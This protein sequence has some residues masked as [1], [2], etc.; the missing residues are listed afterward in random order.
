MKKIVKFFIENQLLVYLGLIVVVIFGV[1][2]GSKMNTSFFPAEKEK[3]ILIEAVYPGASPQEIEEGITLKIEDNLK[4]VSGIDRV[5]SVSYENS[6]RITVEILLRSN[7][8]Q[9]LQDVKNAVDQIANFPEGMERIVTYKQEIINFTAKLAVVGDVSLAALEETAT[10]VEDELR[11]IPGI[12]KL[13]VSGYPD[14]E[15]EVAVKEDKLRAYD[16]TFSDIAA[17]VSAQNIEVTGGR[18]KGAEETIIRSNNK[19]YNANQL[20]DVVVKSLPDGTQLKLSELAELREDWDESTN[21]GYLNGKRAVFI[22]VNTLNEEDILSA[23]D[24]VE[25]YVANFSNPNPEVQLVLVKDGTVTLKERI[26]LLQKNGILGAILVFVILALF[27]RIRLAFWVALGIPV[28]FLGMFILLYFTGITIN[29]LSLFG[30]ILVI[31]ILVDDGIVVG[32]NIFQ[33]Y[34]RGKKPFR[35]VVDGTVEVFPS[36]FSAIFTTCVAFSFFYFVDGRLGEFFSDVAIVVSAAL[37]FSLIEVIFFLPAH[38]AHSKDLS[39]QG[40]PG[41]LKD[42]IEQLLFRFR[43][44]IFEPVLEFCLRYKVFTFFVG[45]ALFVLTIAAIGGGLI[46]TTFFP[47]IEQ[48]EITVGLEMP[49]GTSEKVTHEAMKYIVRRIEALNQSYEAREDVGK[50][51]YTDV[52]M[53]L[54]PRSNEGK[55]TFYLVSSE[56]RSLRSFDITNDM[57]QAVGGIPDAEKLSFVAFSPFGKA[58]NV[59]FS[60]PDFEKLRAAVADF[61]EQLE[62][63]GKVKDLLTNDRADQPEI[64]LALNEAGR[65][66][67]FSERALIAQVRSGFF[68]FEAQRLQRGDKEVKVWVRYDIDDRRS[69]QQLRQMRVRAPGGEL[70]ALSDIAEFQP[71]K[72]LININH[73]NGRREITVEGEVASLDVS[74]P[75]LLAQMQDEILPTVLGRYPGV[76]VS[77]EGQQRETG[78]LQASTKTAGPIILLVILITLIISFRS[79]TQALALLVL[80]PFGIIG[81]AWGHYIHDQPI[82]VLSFLGIIALVGILI[83]DGLVFINAFNGYLKEGMPYNAALKETSLTRFRPLL[84]T[85]ITTSAGLGPLILEKSFQAQFLIPMAISIAYGLLL[86]SLFIVLLLPITLTMFNRLKVALKWLWEGE[87]PAHEEVEQV[88]K[89]NKQETF[90]L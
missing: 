71:Q 58:V 32:E 88:V 14:P 38:L 83:N 34:E 28:S 13:T 52:E 55:A 33:H 51:M 8:D 67:G 5:T 4:G 69:V 68:G 3:F 26:E 42:W 72:G 17:A 70:V 56:E 22:T 78:K 35:A 10:L 24:I 66:M 74:T 50:A 90:E 53:V 76:D 48:N 19:V 62:Q 1:T 54:G 79:Y 25:N 89:R 61:T 75:D 9:V 43:N 81:A 63:T 6:A 60:S 39:K 29:V 12:S 49:P 11:A 46:R 86:G 87:K 40:K 84:L 47:N 30:M 21:A 20:R 27:L 82:S 64:N 18:I 36:V 73:R 41:K 44:K 31:G 45:L 77:F 23:A 37:A 80:V 65:A 7:I 15:I 2:L 16:L 59:S 57:R 85:T